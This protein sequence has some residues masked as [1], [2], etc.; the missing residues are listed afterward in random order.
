[1]MFIMH[2]VESVKVLT[3]NRKYLVSNDILYYNTRGHPCTFTCQPRLY[4]LAHPP[5]VHE[6]YTFRDLKS[7]YFSFYFTYS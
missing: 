6:A 7:A 5:C 3:F 2:K 1:M 4:G